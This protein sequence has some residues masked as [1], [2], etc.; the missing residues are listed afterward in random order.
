MT[1]PFQKQAGIPGS[2]LTYIAI[3]TAMVNIKS[4]GSINYIHVLRVF[5]K[6]SL[7]LNTDLVLANSADPDEMPHNNNAAFHLGL[8]CL[9]R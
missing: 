2:V 8:H 3:T 7:S 9:Q 4:G 1:F 6:I 5:H